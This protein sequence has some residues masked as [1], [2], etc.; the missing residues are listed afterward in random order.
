LPSSVTSQR[1]P[2]RPAFRGWIG[3]RWLSTDDFGIYSIQSGGFGKGDAGLRPWGI[4]QTI[5]RTA[6][7]PANGFRW[8]TPSA[9]AL[10]GGAGHSIGTTAP[11]GIG[12]YDQLL[13]E[14]LSPTGFRSVWIKTCCKSSGN[15]AVNWSRV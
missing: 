8:S 14:W 6:S 9:I 4:I 2:F 1:K 3:D 10:P 15:G 12:G 11:F 7:G 13:K 5:K